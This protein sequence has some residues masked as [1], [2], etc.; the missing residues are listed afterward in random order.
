MSD[1]ETFSWAGLIVIAGT[2]LVGGAIL[3]SPLPEPAP[4]LPPKAKPT[5]RTQ[6]ANRCVRRAEGATTPGRRSVKM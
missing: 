6:V 1:N 2:L 5:A 3:L 4:A